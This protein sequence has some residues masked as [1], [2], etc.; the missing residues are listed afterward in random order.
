MA[1]AKTVIAKVEFNRRAA[2]TDWPEPA[3]LLPE[4][5]RPGVLLWPPEG[6]RGDT[7]SSSCASAPEPET[8]VGG[9]EEKCGKKLEAVQKC[10][11]IGTRRGAEEL[12]RFTNGSRAMGRCLGRALER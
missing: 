12:T 2:Q 8:M 5:R 4:S 6:G 1:R 11:R 7:T 10:D 3:G 9:E